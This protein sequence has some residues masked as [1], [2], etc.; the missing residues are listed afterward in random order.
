MGLE[1]FIGPLIGIGIIFALIKLIK[2]PFWLIKNS[3]VGAIMLYISNFIGLF[4]I[5]VTFIHALIA[6]V[7]GIPGI[8]LLFIYLNFIKG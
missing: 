2:L 8:I 7:F 4:T 5:K 6:G 3:I 1:I